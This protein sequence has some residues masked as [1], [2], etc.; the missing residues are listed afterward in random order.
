MRVGLVVTTYERPLA[1]VRVLHSVL[2]QSRLPDQV[3]VADDGSGP[4]TAGVV[5]AVAERAG[6][7]VQH[8]RQDDVGWRLCRA[9]NLAV[10]LLDTE[11]V[12]MIDGD[13][14]LDRHFVEDHLR[15]A[16]PGCWVQ[17]SR[18]PLGPAA[19]ARALE[20]EPGCFT[21][22]PADTDLRHRPLARRR[23]GLAAAL[24]RVGNAL[25]AVKGC[26]Q[27]FW[28]ADLQRVNGWD[29]S[30]TGWGPEDKELCARLGH[31]GVRRQSLVA[32]GLAWHLHHP[33]AD[34]NEAAAGHRVLAATLAARRHR[35]E[36]GLDS[37]GRRPGPAVL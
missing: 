6:L 30:I 22:R 27:G 29:E 28:R 19:T 9:R 33:P 25:V 4:Q 16:R 2:A 34:R 17:G 24:H 36:Q 1:L 37:H 14:L 35:C 8:A 10:S 26:N 18:L 32:A 20:Q 12:L 23:P 5:A 21:A 13:M 15:H 11:Y 31:A 3:V 7:P